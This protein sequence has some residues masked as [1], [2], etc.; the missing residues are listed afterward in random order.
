MSAGSAGLGS[1]DSMALAT[2]AANASRGQGIGLLGQV[3]IPAASLTD[4]WTKIDLPGLG[5]ALW[6]PRFYYI[7]GSNPGENDPTQVIAVR[8]NSQTAFPYLMSRLQD[9]PNGFVT[10][11]SAL[12]VKL[13]TAGAGGPNPMVLGFGVNVTVTTSGAIGSGDPVIYA[14]DGLDVFAYAPGAGAGTAAAA[15]HGALAPNVGGGR[16]R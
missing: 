4:A 12:W 2:D 7:D 11:I 14:G 6:L 5:N 9:F 3:L 13:V 15:S 16:F 10:S 8:L 1:F